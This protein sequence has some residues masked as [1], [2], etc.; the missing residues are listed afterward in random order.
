MPA[1]KSACTATATRTRSRMTPEQEE[2][3]LDKCIEVIDEADGQAAARLHRAVVGVEPRDRRAPAQEGHHVRPQHDPQRLPALLRAGRRQL[4]EDRLFAEPADLDEAAAAR[5]RDRPDRDPGELVPRR[6]AADDVH[7]EGAQQPRLRQSAR[8]RGAVA[9]PVRLGLSR[10]GL[11]GVPDR[12]PPGRRRA[13]AG[14][15]DAR[16][17]LSRT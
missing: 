1:T 5:H 13:A 15:A 4:D 16:T 17:A 10:D 7:Q 6:P 3:V 14:A 8:H 2:A 9:R 12:D 11:C